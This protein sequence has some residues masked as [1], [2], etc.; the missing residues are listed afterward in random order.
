VGGIMGNFVIIQDKKLLFVQKNLLLPNNSLPIPRQIPSYLSAGSLHYKFNNTKYKTPQNKLNEL[1]FV[2]KNK[3]KYYVGIK[4]DASLDAPMIITKGSNVNT[5]KKYCVDNS[6]PIV[7]SWRTK[8]L[9]DKCKINEYVPIPYWNMLAKII[10]K[11]NKRNKG[12][13]NKNYRT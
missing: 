10:K 8:Y 1:S 4:Y 2:I 9:S 3:N 13:Q 11:I 7:Q 5:I 6:I 12:K